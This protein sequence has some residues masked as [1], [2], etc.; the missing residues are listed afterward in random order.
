MA[1]DMRNQRLTMTNQS[2]PGFEKLPWR[3][4][5]NWLAILPIGSAQ[6]GDKLDSCKRL[7]PQ[8]KIENTWLMILAV[9]SDCFLQV[10]VLSSLDYLHLHE[11]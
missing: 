2:G 6:I 1:K 10:D 4:W 3:F 5:D 11:T 9:L 7:F 8:R